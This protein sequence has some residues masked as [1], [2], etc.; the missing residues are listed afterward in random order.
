MI[1]TM[2]GYPNLKISINVKYDWFIL[3]ATFA[4]FGRTFDKY[5]TSKLQAMW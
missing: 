3:E 5:P 2:L 1:C 4:E